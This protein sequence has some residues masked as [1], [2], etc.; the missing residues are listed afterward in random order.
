M[1]YC[2]YNQTSE[3]FLSLGVSLTHGALAHLKEI[4]R[5]H[6][7]TSYEGHWILEPKPI[8]T[9]GIFAA[10]DLVYLDSNYRVLEVVESLPS[11]RIAR[12]EP[13]EI[14]SLLV[15]PVHTIYTS[16]TQPGNQLV[17][18]RTEEMPYRLRTQS[19]QAS[20]N[21]S[22]STILS[23]LKQLDMTGWAGSQQPV[24]AQNREQLVVNAAAGTALNVRGVRDVNST[25][26][27]LMTE[28]R[29]PVGT[30][31]AMTLKRAD[32]A[33]EAAQH[34][35]TVELRVTRWGEDGIGLAFVQPEAQNAALAAREH[36]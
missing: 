17:I 22:G 35:I 7:E 20:E 29:W 10:R 6:P 13:A 2:V 12:I 30:E 28:E 18:G 33:S 32:G 36:G 19:R 25:G 9:L 21:A 24:S 27:Y 11:L 26:I 31:V 4:L 15:L 3:C 14:A 23:S 34:L 5:R 16:Q 1:K 8:H